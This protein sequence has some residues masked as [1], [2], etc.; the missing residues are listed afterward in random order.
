MLVRLNGLG[1]RCA[2]ADHRQAV[3]R[4]GGKALEEADVERVVGVPMDLRLGFGGSFGGDASIVVVGAAPPAHPHPREPAAELYGGVAATLD[5]LREAAGAGGAQDRTGWNQTLR[6][7]EDEKRAEEREQLT[8]DRA[9][10]HPM[11]V[12][13]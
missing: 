6:A 1:L 8:D 12:Y 10:L 13:G 9:P 7:T 4:S 2:R 11:R 5:A 3:A